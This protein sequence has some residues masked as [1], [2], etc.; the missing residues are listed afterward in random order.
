MENRPSLQEAVRALRH[1]FGDTQDEFARRL[2][3]SVRSVLNY[4]LD[5]PPRGMRLLQ[6]MQLSQSQNLPDLANIFADHSLANIRIPVPT[7]ECARLILSVNQLDFEITQVEARMGRQLAAE[8]FP[9]IRQRLELVHAALERFV[10]ICYQEPADIAVVQSKV[11][12]FDVLADSEE[13]RELT[14]AM[15]ARRSR[16]AKPTP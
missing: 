1:S 7:S 12:M 10:K 4:E 5:K 15:K 16:K 8:V 9:K 3:V 6:L 14:D 11:N 2:G 13:R